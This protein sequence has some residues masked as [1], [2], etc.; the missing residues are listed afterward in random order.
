MRLSRF[1]A[2]AIAACVLST[3]AEPEQGFAPRAAAI[4][5]PRLATAWNQTVYEIAFAEDEFFT[6]KGHR[7]HAMMHLAIHDALNAVIPHYRTIRVP[8]TRFFCGSHR[9]RG[10]GSPRR[11]TVAVSR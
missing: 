1:A 6:F 5:D 3:A 10:A 9:S 8:R 4:S 11:R 7:A 2:V